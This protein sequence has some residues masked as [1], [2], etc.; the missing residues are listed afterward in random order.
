MWH[1]AF[2]HLKLPEFPQRERS[3]LTVLHLGRQGPLATVR[4]RK[5][6][7]EPSQ[8]AVSHSPSLCPRGLLKDTSSISTM[9]L[10]VSMLKPSDLISWPRRQK[11]CERSILWSSAVQHDLL[12]GQGSPVSAPLIWDPPVCAKLLSRRTL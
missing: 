10:Q 5:H 3:V 9:I 1:L 11:K 2:P 12:G 4:G 7:F 8:S 6:V